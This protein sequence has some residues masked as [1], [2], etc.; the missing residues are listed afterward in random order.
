MN[1]MINANIISHDTFRFREA[2]EHA[3]IVFN[4][5]GT[6]SMKPVHPLKY[7][8][9]MSNGTEEDLVIMPNIALFVSSRISYSYKL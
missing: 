3:D 1:I 4:D 7:I 8:P 6:L 9:E 5:N 2:L